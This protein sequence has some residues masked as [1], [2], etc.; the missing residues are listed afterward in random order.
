[1]T[2]LETYENG[3]LVETTVLPPEPPT[4]SDALA[5]AA[6]L[7]V[8]D[9]V[10]ADAITAADAPTLAPLFD[11][12]RPGEDVQVGDLRRWG[13]T[14]VE[15]LQAHTT[16]ADWTPD[17]TPALWRTYRDPEAETPAG[18]TQPTG[19]H[20]AYNIGDRVTFNGEVY[21]SLIDGNVHS[22]AAYP[23]GWQV[24]TL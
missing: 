13:G 18:W 10:Q 21:E 19:A 12:W 24:V 20:D 7:V 4:V 23:D 15:C 11:P 8:A 14:L 16:Q 2:R 22:P 5:A 3:V 9:K 6:R 1:M 17:A